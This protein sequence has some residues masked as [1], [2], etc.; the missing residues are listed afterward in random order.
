MHAVPCAAAPELLT[1]L[2]VMFPATLNHPCRYGAYGMRTLPSFNPMNLALLDRGFLIGIAH[3][4]GG[5]E[6]G[7]AWHLGAKRLSKPNTFEDYVAAA[8]ALVSERWASARG[9]VGWGRSAGGLAVGA[10]INMRP[11]LF[12]MIHRV[13][14]IGLVSL[15]GP[16]LKRAAGLSPVYRFTLLPASACDLHWHPTVNL[17]CMHLP[18]PSVLI[19]P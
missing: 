8:E 16:A 17:C 5:G 9:L 2:S 3:V 1:V 7:S 11:G 14:S 18:L 13:E 10:A 15:G 6:L 19:S 12:Q 4:R